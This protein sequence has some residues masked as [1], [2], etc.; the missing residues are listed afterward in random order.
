VVVPSG[1]GSVTVPPD[2]AQFWRLLDRARDHR[3][4]PLMLLAGNSGLRRGELA[5]LR[6]PDIDLA[7]GQQM[8][9]QQRKSIINRVAQMATKA[10]ALI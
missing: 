9:R 4:Y 2:I 1:G 7:T 6:W 8:V 5:G 3:L 10:E